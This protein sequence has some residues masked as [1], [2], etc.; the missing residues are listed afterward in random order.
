M[1]VATGSPGRLEDVDARPVL[2]ADA[3]NGDGI[4]DPSEAALFMMIGELNHADNTF[5]VIQPDAD[6]LAW[7][8]SVSLLDE[9]GYEVELRDV[10]YREHE[11][12]V[13]DDFGHI[14]NPGSDRAGG[15][16]ALR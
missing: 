12:T 6:D 2:R 16:T 11:L 1:L 8:A 15:R 4:D 3:E 10:R 13:Q 14:A 7:V 9:G 5:V